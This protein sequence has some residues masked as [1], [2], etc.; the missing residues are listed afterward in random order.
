MPPQPSE[1]VAEVMGRYFKR[2]SIRKA[3]IIGNGSSLF[4]VVLVC[5]YNSSIC[6]IEGTDA[7]GFCDNH[8]SEG[9]GG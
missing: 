4:R 7:S 3:R 6:R 5:Y 2:L 1:D 9:H 8:F